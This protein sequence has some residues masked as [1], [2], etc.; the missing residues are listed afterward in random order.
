MKNLYKSIFLLLLFSVSNSQINLTPLVV[1]DNLG[2]NAP[3]F[4]FHQRKVALSSTGIIMATWTTTI[5]QGGQVVYSLYD[6]AFGTWTPPVAISNAPF[7]ALQSALAAD[8][9]G[10]IHAIWQQKSTST[11]KYQ[12]FYSKFN[13][14]NWTTPQKISLQASTIPCEEATIEIDS[15]G[16]IWVAY[17][18][19]G[20][21]APNEFVFARRSLDA[22][23]TWSATLDTLSKG[24]E[25]GTSIETGRTSFAAGPNGKLVAIWDNSL[26][27]KESRREVFFNQF[28]GTSWKGA[29]RISDITT[30]DRDH[31]RYTTVAVDS[32]GNI[33]A[34]YVASIISASDARPKRVLLHKKSWDADWS[35]QT[36]VIHLDSN[37]S[38]G[39]P[40]ALCDKNGVLHLTFRIDVKSDTTYLLDEIIYTFSKDKGLTWKEPIVISRNLRDAN[41]V[42]IAN[43]ITVGGGINFLWRESRDINKNDQDTTAV[44]YANIPYSY[45]TKVKENEIPISYQFLSNYPNPFNSETIINYQ[46]PTKSKVTLKIFDL[47]GREIST[48][49][50]ETKEMGNYKVKFSANKFSGGIY[51]AQLK[52]ENKILTHKMV[53][54]K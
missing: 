21:T 40:S 29:V 15:K 28:D 36:S 12:I 27:G 11:E 47:L 38:Q 1:Q 34:I 9:I 44:V 24:G 41:Y 50:N 2:N 16:N 51:F 8:E 10:N 52:T 53:F 18:T 20:A 33:Y 43:R 35:N 19:D 22:G 46:L 37:A 14:T 49:V 17:N 45:V 48:L 25:I 32:D 7:Q 4:Y 23:Q 5:T 13:G 26:T 6:N 39:S 31:N 54:A 3:L 42:T 30:I